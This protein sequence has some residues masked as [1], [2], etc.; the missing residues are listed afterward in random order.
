[1]HTQAHAP[2]RTAPAAPPPS[3]LLADW[4]PAI[5][6]PAP[7]GCRNCNAPLDPTD[8]YCRGC[9]QPVVAGRLTLRKM[10]AQAWNAALSLD[11]GLL[12]TSLQL[13]H[14]PG[15]LVRD[16]LAG[17]TA[18][19]TAPFKYLLLWMGL[20]SLVIY[21]YNQAKPGAKAAGPAVFAD[22]L[23]RYG[24]FFYTT[25]ADNPKLVLTCFILGLAFAARLV[26]HRRGLNLAEHTVALAYLLG[27]SAL[28]ETLLYLGLLAF[29]GAIPDSYAENVPHAVL[30]PLTAGLYG[31][32]FNLRW[33]KAALAGAA[34]WVLG[35]FLL[36]VLYTACLYAFA[37]G[38]GA[39]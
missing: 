8:R 36:L 32:L 16:Y 33:W 34:V 7:L 18:S 25:L 1:M 17:K 31:Q 12:F 15:H 21:W 10:G 11:K 35:F 5:A 26:F 28:V 6:L 22:E 3:A 14:R 23:E 37:K 9:A 30:L 38:V 39:I 4:H 19:Y 20:S 13:F 27:T 24:T 29:P 2:A